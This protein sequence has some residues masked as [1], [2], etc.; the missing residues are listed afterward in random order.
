MLTIAFKRRAQRRPACLRAAAR[1]ARRCEDGFLLVEVM[2][3]AL[4]MALVVVATLTGLDV[5]SRATADERRHSEAIVLAAQSQEQLRSDPASALSELYATPHVYEKTVGGT[6]YTITQTAEPLNGSGVAAGCGATETGS[7]SGTRVLITS[8]V[9]WAQQ[10]TLKRPAVKA[11]SVITPPTGSGLEVDVQ[12]GATPPSG[13]SGVAIRVT[14]KPGE[15]GATSWLEATTGSNGCT[16]FTAIPATKATVEVK[17]KLNFVTTS[18]APQVLPKEKELSLAPNIVTHYPVTYNEGGRITAQFTYK[19]TKQ[20][21]REAGNPKTLEQVKGDTFVVYN[22][23]VGPEPKFTVGSSSFGPASNTGEYSKVGEEHYKPL[24]GGVYYLQ[25]AS[26]PA[27]TKYAS[28][29]LFPFGAN[30]WQVYAGD[31][32]KNSVKAATEKTEKLENSSALVSPGKATV[33]TVPLSYVHLN[34]Y[35]GTIKSVGSLEA[36]SY[37]VKITNKECEA[38]PIANNASA[39]NLVHTQVTTKEGHL[40]DPFQPFGKYQLCLYNEAKKRTYTTT[41]ENT[42]VAGST[43]NLYLAEGSAA[44]REAAEAKAREKREV[45]EAKPREKREAEEAAARAKWEKEKLKK[46]ELTKKLETQTKEREAAENE[47]AKKRAEAVKAEEVAREAA[48]AEEAKL[49]FT[50]LSGQKEC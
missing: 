50:V 8:A 37:A 33:V 44:E 30:S 5:A 18:G 31:C 43:I 16:L 26:T 45:E 19:G 11:S 20:Y 3:S 1:S 48:K 35:S 13:V 2:I 25:E 17:E 15:S 29:D 23:G 39:S 38:E 7:Q 41:F 42:T 28:G 32:P 4:L 24:T 47:E 36:T 27:A 9:S 40:E 49:G 6:T 34:T 46:S 14:Y 21:E 10:R 12:N 22:S